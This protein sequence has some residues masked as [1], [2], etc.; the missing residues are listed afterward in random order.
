M[1][2]TEI[3]LEDTHIQLDLADANVTNDR[4][5]RSCINSFISNGRSVTLVLQQESSD[6]PHL[7]HWYD[8]RMGELKKLP[9]MRFFL[10][11]RNHTIHKA[12]VHLNL[13]TTEV[14]DIL[15]KGRL[16]AKTGT[17][18]VWQF[19]DADQYIPGSNKNMFTIC[20]EYLAL[21]DELVSAW[22][23]E[24]EQRTQPPN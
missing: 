9:V 18:N 5:V 15:H 23:R 17:L 19:D 3:K 4:I 12:S 11:K 16:I 2:E 20:K 10:E 13:H 1:T 21:L 6:N 22:L 14:R 8:K 7:K 24:R